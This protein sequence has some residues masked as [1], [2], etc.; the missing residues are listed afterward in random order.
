MRPL[1]TS[2]CGWQ[3]RPTSLLNTQERDSEEDDAWERL[4]RL[5]PEPEQYFEE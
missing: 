4:R 3:V 2:R 5:G 1:A